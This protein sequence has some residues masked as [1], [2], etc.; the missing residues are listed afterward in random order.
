MRKY[1]NKTKKTMI[2][3][4]VLF[5]VIIVIFSYA[6]KKSIDIDKIA[7]EIPASSIMFDNE[8]NMLATNTEGTLRIKWGGD[9]YLK[10]NDKDYDIGTHAVI[11]NSNNGNIT[12]YGKFYEVTKEGK[13]E[14][15]KGENLIKSSVNSRFYKLADRKY[16]I[17]DRI[18]ESVDSSFVTSN[19]LIINLDKLGNA[20]LLNDK[21]SYK[22][23]T[24]TILRTS[25]YTFDIANEKL[26]FGGEDI[27]LKK[28]IGSTNEYDKDKY[29][30]N[31]TPNDDE[32]PTGT[33]GDGTGTGSGGGN[34]SGSSDGTGTGTGSGGTTGTGDGKGTG[35]GGM[36]TGGTTGEGT[37]GINNTINSNGTTASNNSSF[38]NNY[39]EG[40]SNEVVQDIINATKKTSVIR[41]TSDISSISIDYVVYDPLNEY[42]SVFVE[43]EK[44]GIVESNQRNTI[45][46]SKTDTNIN[47]SDLSPN[48]YYKLAFKYSYYDES[49]RLREDT[50]DE[51]ELYTKMPKIILTATQIVKE[52]D[53][54]MLYYKI[55]FDKKYTI[56]SGN[57][58]LY[59]EDPDTGM[60]KPTEIEAELPKKM[61]DNCTII[62]TIDI[63]N[64]TSDG[65]K[66]L[67]MRLVSL[68]Y[69]GHTI[70]PK[71]GPIV[72]YKF[73]Y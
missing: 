49:Q 59:L 68:R 29:D 52:D 15:I 11:Y 6:I 32:E 63:S 66:L 73:R 7:Y 51:V 9:Y 38:N 12:L 64:L 30:L 26:N 5:I 62:G 18:V 41:V 61:D 1:N 33:S 71:N 45:Y 57:I 24:P 25:A 43:V 13:V 42:K 16:L 60:S 28:I 17:I 72:N 20:T 31:A 22:T 36:G 69:N 47:I 48:T 58:H 67:D 39:S 65:R 34:G 10:Y 8:Y 53:K 27:D 35:S 2:I 70:S 50:F 56:E 46:L 21:T 3:L 4:L 14:V 55:S 19:Y 37:P 54:K 44:V 23:I 40:I